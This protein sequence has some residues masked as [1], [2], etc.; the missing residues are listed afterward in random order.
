MK[1]VKW[2]K[3]EYKELINFVKNNYKSTEWSLII[4]ILSTKFKRTED[5]IKTALIS[6]SKVNMNIPPDSSKSGS[7]GSAYGIALKEAFLEVKEENTISTIKWDYI[8]N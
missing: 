5:A 2:T 1:R 6:C 8:L 3:E 7:R 4:E